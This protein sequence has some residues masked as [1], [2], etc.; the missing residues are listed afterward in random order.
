MP[1][2][3]RDKFEHASALGHV[4]TVNHPMVKEALA[5]YRLPSSRVAD[6]SA[7]ESCLLDPV[8]LKQ[9]SQV[10]RWAMA[11]DS[12]P[13]EHV[14]DPAFPSTRLTFTQLSAVVVDLE[15]MAG[16]VGRFADPVAIREAQRAAV[17]AAVLP[18]SNLLRADGTPPKRAFREAI[19]ELLRTRHV[20]GRSLHDVLA[21]ILCEREGNNGLPLAS[22]PKCPSC[23]TDLKGLTFGSEGGQC[24]A[25]GEELLYADALRAHEQ[26]R[27]HGSNEEACGRVMSVAERLTSL[28]F[29]DH[30]LN[31]RPAAVAKVAF[32]T[33]GPLALFGEVAKLKVPLLIRLQRIAADL[34]ARQLELPV[35]VGIEKSGIFVEH[36]QAIRDHIPRG[37]L[38]LPTEKYIEQYITFRGSPHGS[39]TY[40][41][42]HAFYRSQDN[43]LHV[44]TVPPLGRIG[45]TPHGWFDVSDYPTLAATCGLIE[46]IGTRLYENATIP[47]TLAHRYAA[48]PLE[49]AGRVLKLHVEEHLDRS[50]EVQAA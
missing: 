40:Y 23:D 48:F 19:D 27:E 25:C 20:E 22:V 29:L 7:V 17:I 33:D 4:P 41:G 37:F 32:I 1:Y 15:M 28:A 6:V 46:R 5:R 13:F 35:V 2:R 8:Q 26:F 47:I 16:R 11:T 34:D 3:V 30:V 24:P 18:G 50:P 21:E 45:A 49:T 31:A 9:P 14:V 44:I 43:R 10:P 42:R 39:E 38:M 12:S 36:G